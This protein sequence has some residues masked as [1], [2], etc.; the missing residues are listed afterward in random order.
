MQGFV[1]E[2]F[3]GTYVKNRGNCCKYYENKYVINRV[4]EACLENVIVSLFFNQSVVVVKIRQF[5]VGLRGGGG[6]V[7]GNCAGP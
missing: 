4:Y 2:S 7:L 3:Y 1:A 6:G 5:Y